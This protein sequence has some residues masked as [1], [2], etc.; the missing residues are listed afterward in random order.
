MK[1]FFFVLTVNFIVFACS[2]VSALTLSLADWAFNINGATYEAWYG[3]PLPANFNEDSFDWETGLGELAI[4]FGPGKPGD[5]FVTGFFDHEM[6]ESSNTFFNEYALEINTPAS[7]QTWEV[8][9]PVFDGDIYDNVLAGQLDTINSV[10][11]NSADDVSMAIGWNFSLSGN[12]TAIV[13][14]SLNET[15][16]AEGFYLIQIDKDSGDEIF[17]SSDMTLTGTTPTPEP[18][19]FIMVGLGLIASLGFANTRKKN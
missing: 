13:I 19:T 3:D 6:V 1:S 9:E 16:P 14:F 2:S 12:E 18:G 15:K 4:T 8:D 7:G 17:F 10:S 11:S 5:Y